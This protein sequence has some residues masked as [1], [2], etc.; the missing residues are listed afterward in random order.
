MAPG[1]ARH[2]ER[3]GIAPGT[4]PACT[5]SRRPRPSDI[6]AGRILPPRSEDS[7]HLASARLFFSGQ[8][9]QHPGH[10]IDHA[11]A[12]DTTS[13]TAKA[14]LFPAAREPSTGDKHGRSIMEPAFGKLVGHL[15]E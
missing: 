2:R 10:S 9:T 15:L 12:S 1:S 6:A 13:R 5:S 11:V 14:S 4:G 3:S 7:E 8:M